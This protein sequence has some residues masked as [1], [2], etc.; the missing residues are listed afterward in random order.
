MVSKRR[1][2]YARGRT[3]GGFETRGDELILDILEL[4]I[5]SKKRY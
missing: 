1:R 4:Q 2:K 5:K 3:G